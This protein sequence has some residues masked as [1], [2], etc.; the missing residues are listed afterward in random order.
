MSSTCSFKD[1]ELFFL[2]FRVPAKRGIAKD[3][4]EADAIGR[5]AVADFNDSLLVENLSFTTP[6]NATSNTTFK[7][8]EVKKKVSNLQN[9]ISQMGA[10]MNVFSQHDIL[11]IGYNVDLEMT[12]SFLLR[13]VPWSLSTHARI[14]TKTD[15]SKLLHDL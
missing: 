8:C 14:L 3:L 7:A 5:K 11:T 4:N 12:L 15:K 1:N 10:K 13:P 2:S 9:V 6:L